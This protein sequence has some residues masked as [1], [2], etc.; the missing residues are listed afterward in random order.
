MQSVKWAPEVK[1]AQRYCLAC[2]TTEKLGRRNY[3]SPYCRE[4]LLH[5]LDLRVGLLQA[6]GVRFATFYFSDTTIT[7]DMLLYGAKS[8]LRFVRPRTKGNKPSHD[9]AKLADSLGAVWWEERNRSHKRFLA[10]E[11]VL[12]MGIICREPLN[13]VKPNLVSVPVVKI[14][15]LSA[16]HITK[17]DLQGMN[18]TE[19]IK[20]NYRNQAKVLHPDAGG[21]SDDFR[22]LYNAYRDIRNWLASPRYTTKMGFPDKWFYNST[23]TRWVPPKPHM[24]Q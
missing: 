23:L 12:D 20:E 18:I 2:G 10:N 19:R 14:E 4:R 22:Y 21:S 1:R 11:Q 16:M 15:T 17:K 24:E 7:L 3:C 8:I 13:T 9:F 6:L 5:V